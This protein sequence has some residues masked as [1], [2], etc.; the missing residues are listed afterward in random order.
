MLL[1]LFN[2]YFNQLNATINYGFGFDQLPFSWIPEMGSEP[3]R[4]FWWMVKG[5]SFIEHISR[6]LFRCVLFFFFYR[7]PASRI[8]ARCVINLRVRV[9]M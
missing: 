5:E 8:E 3:K 1:L 4:A 2:Y 7:C 6:Y 9:S